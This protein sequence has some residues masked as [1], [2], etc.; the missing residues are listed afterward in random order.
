MRRFSISPIF[1]T[2]ALGYTSCLVAAKVPESRIRE[3]ADIISRHPGVSHNYRRDGDFNI[4]FTLAVPPGEDLQ[5]HLDRLG[6]EASLDSVRPMPALRVFR[7]GVKLDMTGTDEAE[8]DSP[9]S[10]PAR[11]VTAVALTDFDK[12]VIRATQGD[13][14]LT[15]RP[16]DEACRQLAIDF[17]ALVE[18][19]DRMREC[20]V[21]RRMAAILHHRTAGFTANGMA[22][23]RVPEDRIEEAG[24]AAAEFSQVSHCYHR[25]SYPDWPYNLFAMIHARSKDACEEVAARIGEKIGIPDHRILYSTEQFKK[26]RVKYFEEIPE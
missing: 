4:W 23:W 17:A 25:P 19:M 26:V 21:L 3:A 22:V 10:D 2:R 8:A 6:A 20:G 7:I 5:K 15:E 12:Q 18:W 9:E 11:K 13:L 24:R 1:D 16:F 14:P